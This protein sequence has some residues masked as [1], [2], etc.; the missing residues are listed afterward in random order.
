MRK[1]KLVFAAISIT[2]ARV[3]QVNFKRQIWMRAT[4]FRERWRPK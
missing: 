1:L 2:L 3:K 4:S